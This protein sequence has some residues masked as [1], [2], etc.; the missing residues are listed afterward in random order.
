MHG[1][2][3]PHEPSGRDWVCRGCD[4]AFHGKPEHMTDEG[5]NCFCSDEC[6]AEWKAS[7]KADD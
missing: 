3:E 5:W 7:E 4:V 2:P 6:F 1:P